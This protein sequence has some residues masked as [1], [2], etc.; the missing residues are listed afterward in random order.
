[1]KVSIDT[2]NLNEYYISVVIMGYVRLMKANRPLINLAMLI[3]R[4]VLQ[5]FSQYFLC[6]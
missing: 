2:F 1:M 3:H 4:N 5:D 6:V